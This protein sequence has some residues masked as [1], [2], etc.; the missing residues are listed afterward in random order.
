M[1]LGSSDLSH[2]SYVFYLILL[3][4]IASASLD[5]VLDGYRIQWLSKED[6]V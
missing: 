5:I 4:S 3:I 6:Y 2:F 1:V